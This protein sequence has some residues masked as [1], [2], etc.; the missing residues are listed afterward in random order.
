M[1]MSL[2]PPELTP[3]FTK[4]LYLLPCYRT[5][6]AWILLKVYRISLNLCF[7]FHGFINICLFKFSKAR[8]FQIPSNY[9]NSFTSYT[10]SP[11][12]M[13]QQLHLMCQFLEWWDDPAVETIHNC[14]RSKVI[15]RSFNDDWF[16]W[17]QPT[18]YNFIFIS[19]FHIRWIIL[20]RIYPFVDERQLEKTHM[21]NMSWR[22][23][24]KRIRE[25]DW[26]CRE[27]SICKI[28]W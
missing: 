13:H 25:M 16:P 9:F 2:L 10:N 28:M 17:G 27:V 7:H 15:Y 4:I 8:H 11:S 23:L 12:M 21:L 26:C 1:I 6:Q 24:N 22:V 3:D 18:G 5:F 19:I 20:L 14:S